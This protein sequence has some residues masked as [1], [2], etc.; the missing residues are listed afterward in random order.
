MLRQRLILGPVLI[1]AVFLAAWLDQWLDGQPLP[2]WMASEARGTWPP[3]V[4]VFAILVLLGVLGAREL[5]AILRGKGVEASARVN[6]VASVLGLSVAALIPDAWGGLTAGEASSTATVVVLVGSLVFF[7]RHRQ[8]QGMIAAAGGALLAYAYLGLLLGF[9]CAIRREHSVWVLLWVLMTTKSCD[10]G[11]YFTGKSI[12]R[13]KLIVWL[14]PGKTWEG[15]I[16]GVAFAGVVGAVGAIVLQRFGVPGAPGAGVG[17]VGGVVF[18]LVGQMGDLLASLLKRDAGL[19]DS[20]ST[21]PGFGGILDV[22][23]SPALVAPVAFWG[24]R[25]L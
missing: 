25:L 11:A 16:G 5:A 23:D 3:G 24:L 1:L 2:G 19:K 21:L 10:I 18:G 13:H 9:L 15:L 17:A 4:M 12:G 22:I 8:V 20:G 14:S 6:G 7:S